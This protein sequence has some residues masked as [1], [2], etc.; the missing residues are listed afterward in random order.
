MSVSARNVL[1][2]DDDIAMLVGLTALLEKN[3]FSVTTCANSL[4]AVSLA[5]EL[6]PDMIVCD[7]MM[8]VMDGYKIRD[9]LSRAACTRNIPFLYLSARTSQTDKLRGFS[10]GADD[11][12]T[13]PFDSRE[14]LARMEAIL[15]RNEKRTQEMAEEF[16]QQIKRI[17]AEV[18]N[19]ISHELRTPMMQILMSL[20]MILRE[21][22]KDPNELK[23]FVETAL[24]QSRRLNGLID[25]LTF[26]TNYDMGRI[27]Y[28]RQKVDVKYDFL[29][30]ISYRQELYRD[31]ELNVKIRVTDDL[32]IHAPRREFRQAVSHL[33]DNA[34][35]FC[36][37]AGHIVIELDA[38]GYGGAKLTC[39]DDG[40]GIRNDLH[41]KVFERYFQASQG[42]TRAYGGL[43]VGL[44]IARAIAHTLN[45]DVVL[46]PMS[47]GCKVQMIIPPAPLDMP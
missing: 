46:H 12:L 47:R 6:Q 36:N 32:N 14:L 11:Y 9:Q 18:S 5:Q 44:T 30:I 45:G 7:V 2:I 4:E 20:E 17:Q 3:H 13:K 29:P 16:E 35:K 21:R 15:R 34:L 43:G 10:G 19:N 28:L 38:N 8:P 42:D 26:L 39:T 33:V 22:Y 1:L 24:S 23:W 31:K 27:Q 25:D 41:E 37:P 40:P